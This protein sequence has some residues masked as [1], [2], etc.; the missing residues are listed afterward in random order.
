MTLLT[1][2]LF[3][4]I[5]VKSTHHRA[6]ISGCHTVNLCTLSPT[7]IDNFTFHCLNCVFM[8]SAL[9]YAR[10]S[11]VVW[12]LQ[13]TFCLRAIEKWFVWCVVKTKQK[14]SF[15]LSVALWQCAKFYAFEISETISIQRYE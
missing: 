6:R 5:R 2:S 12:C 8:Y 3:P 9:H 15:Q 13:I 7:S 11:I 4:A 14:T 1:V 10:D